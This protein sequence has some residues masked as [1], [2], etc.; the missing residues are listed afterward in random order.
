VISLSQI[1]A[2]L[3]G[4]Y[5]LQIA[6]FHNETRRKGNYNGRAIVVNAKTEGSC[7]MRRKGSLWEVA[8]LSV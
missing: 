7:E 5:N 4:Y 6:V 3:D 8:S 2:D 1:T